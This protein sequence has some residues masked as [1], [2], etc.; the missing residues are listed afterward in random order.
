M[1]VDG[2]RRVVAAADVDDAVGE[3]QP[4]DPDH[5][6]V[7]VGAGAA[8]MEDVQIAGRWRRRCIRRSARE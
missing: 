8:Q 6:V 3:D 7:A 2:D 1:V 4:L 5:L